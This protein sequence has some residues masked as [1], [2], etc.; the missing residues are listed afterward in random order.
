MHH[1]SEARGHFPDTAG[2]TSLRALGLGFRG[3]GLRVYEFRGLGFR[4][5]VQGVSSRSR[6]G[7]GC[8]TQT[9]S[10]EMS[11]LLNF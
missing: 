5:S 2:P 11:A 6:G 3:L 4:E 10:S 8:V 7:V 9:R 1:A